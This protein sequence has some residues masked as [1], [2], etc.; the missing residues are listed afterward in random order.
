MDG[1]IL[2]CCGDF[3]EV[4]VVFM[5]HL[6]T[7]LELDAA[8]VLAGG[9]LQVLVEQ[10]RQVAGAHIHL[11]GHQGH[12]QLLPDMGGDEDL[13][14]ADDLVLA[15]NGVGGL[16]LAAGG[17]PGFTQQIQQQQGQLGDDD[18]IGE[19]VHPLLLPQHLLQQL[20]GLLGG[21]EFPVHQGR[22]V[23][24]RQVEG[25]RHIPGRHADVGVLHMPLSGSIN[26]D[27]ALLQQQV[28]AVRHAVE[29][30]LIH[31]GQLRH[32][33][34]LA[35]EQEALLL[36]LVEEGIQAV[37]PHLLL[38]PQAAAAPGAHDLGHGLRGHFRRG[39]ALEGHQGEQHAALDTDGL[40][41]IE[42]LVGFSVMGH[43]QDAHAGAAGEPDLPFRPVYRRAAGIQPQ[44]LADSALPGG[45]GHM[46]TLRQ[47]GAEPLKAYLV[48]IADHNQ[49]PRIK[50]KWSY[51]Q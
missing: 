20:D 16:Q 43:G 31:I 8:D 4:Q 23:E 40:I 51:L 13:S 17:I 35:G 49:S 22:D 39:I 21:S 50:S 15:V 37:Y 36:F 27:V 33:M 14:L 32:G 7:L 18:L 6:L 45:P 5:D 11:P 29:A 41:Q 26:D 24:A 28:L 1:G 19:L 34:G 25:Q 9:Y 47:N 10:G 3:G 38:H 30:A 12:R 2:Q 44:A 42:M 48:Q 46:A